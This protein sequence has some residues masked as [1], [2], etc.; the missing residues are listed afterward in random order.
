MLYIKQFTFNHYEVNSYILY[1]TEGKCP[2]VWVD[3]GMSTEAE[4]NEAFGFIARNGL[5]P[6]HILLTHAHVDHMAGLPAATRRYDLP[7]STHVDSVS[8]LRTASAFGSYMGFDVPNM[9]DLPRVLLNEGDRIKVADD[10]IE[11]RCVQGHCPGSLCFVVPGLQVV[12]TGDALFRGSIGRTDLPGG[13]FDQLIASLRSR[14]L[15]LPPSF[16]VL[17]GHGDISTISDEL[18]RN[19]FL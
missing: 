6:T 1:S 12:L 15:T 16:E 3:P 17:P 7:V 19:P 11:V 14:V 13:N 9:D 8:L 18:A 4:C 2:C 5:H 10:E